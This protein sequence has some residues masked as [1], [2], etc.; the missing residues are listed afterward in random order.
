[1]IP[2]VAAL[3]TGFV[4]AG[5]YYMH[6][7]RT[8]ENEKSRHRP[9][10]AEYF[11][12]DKGPDQSA[13]RVGF[14]ATRNL[15][16]DDPMTALRH[17]SFT[18][19]HA[20]DIRVAA[21]AASAKAAGLSYNDYVKQTNPFRGRKG[22]KPVYSLSLS[23]EPGDPAATQEN[24][25]KAAD[26]VRHVLGME[27]HQCLIVQHTDTKHPHVHL[28]INR[29]NPQT[30]LFA[31]VGNDRL[32][33]SEWALEWEQ[34]FGKI[35]CPQR[36]ENWKRRDRNTAVKRQARA[37]GDLSVKAGYVKSKGLPPSEI[38][39]WNKHGSHDLGVVRAARGKYQQR[40][41]DNHRQATARKLNDVTLSH[42]RA[43]GST[44]RRI[45][46]SLGVLSGTQANARQQKAQSSVGVMFGA[47]RGAALTVVARLK[48]RSDIA[49]LT[50]LRKSIVRDLDVRRGEALRERKAAFEKMKRVHAWQNRLDEKR[51][52]TYRDSD[53]REYRDRR[54]RFDI[55]KVK[56]PLFG[57]VEL[58]LYDVEESKNWRQA[59]A[60]R[61]ALGKPFEFEKIADSKLEQPQRAKPYRPRDERTHQQIVAKAAKQAT[62]KRK[63][64]QTGRSNG[65][66]RKPRSRRPN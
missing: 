54:A 38:E 4:G 30:G 10:A 19:S 56:A 55:S 24:M 21:V 39:F 52:K 50:K 46:R 13:D 45:D 62:E 43:Y 23:F 44:L 47:V 18:A 36:E 48:H 1:M 7:K 64:K 31:K 5:M 60:D 26:E 2:K 33:L 3:G 59:Q 58:T 42:Q 40:D 16:S 29:V 17:M 57:R 9:S 32:K 53:T 63:S 15:P 34:R 6:D 35:V 25:L 49:K 14:T 61:R 51:C 27:K 37:A 8:D 28:I 65:R 20:H 12:A 66:K 11:L 41:I 22:Q